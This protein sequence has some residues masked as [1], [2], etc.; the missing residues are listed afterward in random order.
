MINLSVLVRMV[1]MWKSLENKQISTIFYCIRL[2]NV[3]N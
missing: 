1:H 2:H 3:I